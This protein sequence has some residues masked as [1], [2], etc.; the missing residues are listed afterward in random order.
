LKIPLFKIKWDK[1]DIKAIEKVVSRGTEWTIGGEADEF[2]KKL[3]KYTGAKYAIVCNSGTSALHAS[4]IALGIGEGDEV[5]VP[6]FSYIAT[7]NCV[8]FVGAKPVFA[9]IE[10][11]TYGLDPK[12]VLKK[13]TNKTKAIIPAHVGGTS[14]KIQELKEIADDYGLFLIEDACE[15]LG[16]YY[17]KKMVGTFG[18]IGVYSFCQNK[19]ITTG[20]GGAIVTDNK[21]LYKKL[22]RLINHG[23]E[24]DFVDL[25]YNWRMSNIVASLGISQLN[26][27]SNNIKRKREIAERYDYAFDGFV[28]HKKGIFETYQLYTRNFGGERESIRKHLNKKGIGNKVYFEPIHLT[29]FYRRLGYGKVNLPITEKISKQALTLPCYPDLTNKEVDIIAKYVIRHFKED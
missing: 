28:S 26:K 23:K 19:I 29:P 25:G 21:E 20:D 24:K 2:E 4:L 16:A 9:D 10:K 18:E 1:N 3:A 14:C 6:S 7:A 5:I 11:E 22:K 15:G 8:L 17:G 13:I 12:D 27:I